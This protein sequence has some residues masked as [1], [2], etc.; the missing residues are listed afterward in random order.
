VILLWA[1]FYQNSYSETVVFCCRIAAL[2]LYIP[3]FE[4]VSDESDTRQFSGT[5]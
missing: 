3:E 4:R 5:T 2:F 1:Y